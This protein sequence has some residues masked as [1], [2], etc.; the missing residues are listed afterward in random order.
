MTVRGIE[1]SK[2][3]SVGFAIASTRNAKFTGNWLSYIEAL[4]HCNSQERYEAWY[5]RCARRATK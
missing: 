2:R 3:A 4:H 5:V 1:K